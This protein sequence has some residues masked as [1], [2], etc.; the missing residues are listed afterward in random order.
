[1]QA[2]CKKC[3]KVRPS[4]GDWGQKAR[5]RSQDSGPGAESK[6]PQ[7]GKSGVTK[8]LVTDADQ[9]WLIFDFSSLL[10]ISVL[11]Y[12]FHYSCLSVFTNW[13]KQNKHHESISRRKESCRLCSQSSSKSGQSFWCRFIKCQNVSCIMIVLLCVISTSSVLSTLQYFFMKVYEPIL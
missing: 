11:Y 5:H 7:A 1:M 10:Q 12:K 9:I 6:L 4:A 13:C 8:R 2:R 3:R